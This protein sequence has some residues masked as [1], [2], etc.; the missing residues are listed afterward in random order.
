[1]SEVINFRID[2]KTKTE[3]Q[4]IAKK[5]GLNLSDVLNVLLRNFV[6]DKEI[7]A[8]RRELSKNVKLV[9]HTPISHADI[10]REALGQAGAGRIGNYDFC[11]F[12][13]RGI[14]RFRGNEKSNP[15]IGKPGNY[16]TAEE[17]RIEVIVPRAIL[18]EVIAKMKSVHPYEEVTY[19]IYPLENF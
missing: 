15:T 1:M 7:N 10:V 6:R 9:V 16:E 3:A 13:C 11:S 8:G 17:E 4:A 14:G 5:M 18:K 12:S 2:K 19:D